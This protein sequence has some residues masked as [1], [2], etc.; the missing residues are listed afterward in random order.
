MTMTF[1]MLCIME[2][3]QQWFTTFPFS[4]SVSRF[5]FLL[6]FWNL[7]TDGRYA[8]IPTGRPQR[9][10]WFKIS[11]IFIV[12]LPLF[13]WDVVVCPV[14]FP[15]MSWSIHYITIPTQ[16]CTM[17]I[18]SFA[19]IVNCSSRLSCI[20]CRILVHLL[21]NLPNC[22]P[23]WGLNRIKVIISCIILD[24]EGILHDI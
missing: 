8:D 18:H 7:I 14:I 1:I 2:K 24:V 5:L 16:H 3:Y 22:K 15:S 13:I 21:L 9:Y 23:K 20:N 11:W 19:A 6:E 12:L 4:I 17:G 10:V